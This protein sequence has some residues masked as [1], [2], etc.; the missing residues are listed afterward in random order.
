MFLT[1]IDATKIDPLILEEGHSKK[2][3]VSCHS[4]GNTHQTG[5]AWS[6]VCL[7]CGSHT[8]DIAIYTD[9]RDLVF[10][11]NT[12]TVKNLGDQNVRYG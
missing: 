7:S 8:W 3:F 9:L 5:D 2:V 10:S 1:G 11:S 4:C 6:A 12:F